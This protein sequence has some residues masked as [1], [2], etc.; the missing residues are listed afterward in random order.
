MRLS[1]TV[2]SLR[3]YLTT[4][5]LSV[6]GFIDVVAELGGEGVDLGYY[7]RSSEE[8]RAARRRL[9]ELGLELACYITSNDFAKPS[10]EERRIE[11][12]K[13]RR[14][15]IEAKEM[16]A[17]ILRVFAGSLREGVKPGDAE[18]WVVEALAA[19]ADYAADE[20]LILAVENHGAHFS[21]VGVVERILEAVGSRSLKLNFDTGN[22]ARAGDDPVA[23][24][25]RLG[26]WVVHVHA[27]DLDERG[28][29]CA[30]GEGVLDFETIVRELSSAGF[31]GY[32][33]VEYEGG[34]DQVLGVGIGL[35]YLKALR[36]KLS[37]LG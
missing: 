37:K 21:R 27:K 30:P 2:Y 29:P 11:V 6:P 34:R 36:L 23:A 14:A 22:F 17:R 15:I 5:L 9:D 33:S 10:E 28:R 16:G 18:R 3:H 19:A 1:V 25:R 31:R 8:R 7:W 26:R 32:Y 12:E 35:G 4:G 24:A 13:V 20:G